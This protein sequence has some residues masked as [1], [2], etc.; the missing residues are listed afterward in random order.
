VGVIFL[1]VGG[2]IGVRLLLLARRTRETPELFMGLAFLIGGCIGYVLEVVAQD[3][4]TLPAAWAHAA[5]M[6][7]RLCV[8]VGVI[9]TALFT[10]KVFRSHEHWAGAVVW[11]IGGLFALS[12]VAPSLGAPAELAVG[13]ESLTRFAA[14]IWGGYEAFRFHGLMRRR[15]ELGLAD[16]LVTNRFLLWGLAQVAAFGG[17]SMRVLDSHGIGVGV[18]AIVMPAAGLGSAIAYWITFFPPDAYRRRFTNSSAHKGP[19]H[20]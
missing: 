11:G 20:A 5:W 4:E 1:G 18:A 12:F 7:G 16:P 10:R 17:L 8:D 3:G 13:I 9:L 15:L 2:A 6:F 19:R 14:P